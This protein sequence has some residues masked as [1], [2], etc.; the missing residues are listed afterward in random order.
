MV[1]NR[2][3][4]R[5]HKKKVVV[6]IFIIIFCLVLYR[7]LIQRELNLSDDRIN[8]LSKCPACFGTSLCQ[9]IESED[10]ILSEYSKW[11]IVRLFNVKNVFYGFWNSRNI[12]VVL[13]KLAYESEL[14][15]LDENVCDLVHLMRDCDVNDAVQ[16]LVKEL[17]TTMS[18]SNQGANSML[19][20][21][22]LKNIEYLQMADWTQ[23]SDQNKVDYLIKKSLQHQSRPKLTNLLTMLLV[24]QEP[25]MSMVLSHHLEP[26]ISTYHG[27]CGRLA[28]FSDAG[29]SLTSYIHSS[30]SLR[31]S[32]SIQLLRMA[33]MFSNNSLGLA[34]YP[35]DWAAENF[36][37]DKSGVVRLVD[38]ENIVLVNQSNMAMYHTPGWNHSYSSD[39]YGCEDDRCF[40]YSIPALCSHA[41]TDHNYYALCANILSPSSFS[42]NLLHTIPTEVMDRHTMIPTLLDRCW[43]GRGERVRAGE[44]LMNILTAELQEGRLG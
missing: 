40:S 5:L 20:W 41:R 8:N 25:I 19:E 35:T 43:R 23:C 30:W 4:L 18:I 1:C 36:A 16:E 11:S 14:V 27:S 29:D 24:N 44:L 42:I 10:I 32:L 3:G 34:I 6:Y 26:F 22:K 13:K 37:V 39:N 15:E 12:S 2:K 28:I 38:L 17:G 31:V 9:A 7:Y 33:S 21:G